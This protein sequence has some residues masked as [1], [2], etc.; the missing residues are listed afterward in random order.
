MFYLGQH[1]KR[2]RVYNGPY[3]PPTPVIQRDK[4]LVIY[5][6]YPLCAS[7]K[8]KFIAS[9]I[10]KKMTVTA[11]NDPDPRPKSLEKCIKRKNIIYI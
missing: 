1:L 9:H 7:W 5:L 10:H 2:Q 6:L 8:I 3:G 4:C 11:I